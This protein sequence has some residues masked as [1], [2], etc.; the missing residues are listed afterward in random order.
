M[1]KA[2]AL[3][4]CGCL[5]LLPAG[6]S[7]KAAE[8]FSVKDY[9]AALSKEAE[10]VAAPAGAEE[11][12]LAAGDALN[13]EVWGQ[14]TLTRQVTVDPSGAIHYPLVGSI[15]AEGMTV[16]ELQAA[17]TKKLARYYHNPLVTVMPQDLAGQCYYVLGDVNSP[18]KF[19]LKAK[20]AVIEAAAAAGGPTQS[21]GEHIILLRKTENKLQIVSIPLQFKNLSG[22][23]A[24]ALAMQVQARD[25]LYLPPSRISDVESFMR[26]LD[27]ILNPLLSIERGVMYWP[28]FK[29][30]LKGSSGEVLVQ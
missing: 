4:L 24:S 15:Q 18:G 28:V 23:H 5:F 3:L 6:C 8:E 17:L 13:I 14:D 9:P 26:S 19:V 7:D 30:A 20:T 12:R 1:I 21:A 27:T 22:K 10:Q 2:L 11:L 16:E 29:E 25:I